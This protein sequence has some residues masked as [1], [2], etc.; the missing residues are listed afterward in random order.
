MIFRID[1]RPSPH[2][3]Y[4][5]LAFFTYTTSMVQ[6]RGGAARFLQPVW[7]IVFC[8]SSDLTG[9]ASSQIIWSNSGSKTLGEPQQDASSSELLLGQP[10]YLHSHL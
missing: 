5:T 4:G 10:E 1:K 9:Y 3:V 6:R 2:L 7:E 8:P